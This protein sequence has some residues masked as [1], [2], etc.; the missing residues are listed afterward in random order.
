MAKARKNFHDAALALLREIRDELRGLRADAAER[1]ARPDSKASV[2]PKAIQ[3]L[4]RT[5]AAAMADKSPLLSR[6]IATE[7]TVNPALAEAY[8]SVFGAAAKVEPRR[9]GEIFSRVS[10]KVFNGY[11]VVR[12]G[13]HARGVLWSIERPMVVT[14]SPDATT[15]VADAR[16]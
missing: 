12:A 9:I 1:P 3:N 8:R 5:I 13:T 10:D 15:S 14:A 11:R 7:V 4:G 2:N 16:G 6:E